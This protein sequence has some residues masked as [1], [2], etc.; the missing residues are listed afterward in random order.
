M[1]FYT[2]GSCPGNGKANATGGYGIVGVNDDNK[3]EFVRSK[4]SGITTNNREEL[5]A[6]LYVML[7]FGEK[8]DDWG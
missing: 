2:D 1:T 6:I 7:N 4:R 8:C 5:K 3:V